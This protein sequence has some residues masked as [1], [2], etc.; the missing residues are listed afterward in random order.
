MH[1]S[2]HGEFS[3]NVK[4]ENTAYSRGPQMFCS[5]AC[6]HEIY[7]WVKTISISLVGWYLGMRACG[8]DQPTVSTFIPPPS[9]WH[10]WLASFHSLAA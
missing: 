9:H 10:V 4:Q 7:A 3:L 1:W 2:L 5:F 8:W 6:G